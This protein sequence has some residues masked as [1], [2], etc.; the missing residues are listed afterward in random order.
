M[1]ETFVITLSDLRTGV[2][3]ARWNV[4][5]EFFEEFE[6]QQV[7]S[8]ELEVQVT[9]RKTG[10]SVDVDLDIRGTL[11]VPCDR[12]LEDV[13]MPVD[14]SPRLK[15][16]FGQQPAGDAEEEDGR[17]LVW[18]PEGESQVDL[19][20]TIYDYSCLSLPI[21][22]C[23]REGECNPEALKHLNPSEEAS[24]DSQQPEDSPFSAL[25]GLFDNK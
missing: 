16:R 18:I 25:K 10:A 12:C 11:T 22:C 23:H 5:T 1:N 9:A 19:A 14:S 7:R 21:Q 20:Q 6:N 2:Y 8:A 4:S 17:E 13:S 3:T 15:V 24:R